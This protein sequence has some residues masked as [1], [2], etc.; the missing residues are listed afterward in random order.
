MKR[1]TVVG[2]EFDSL[3]GHISACGTGTGTNIKPAICNA[4]RQMFK[5]PQLKYAHIGSFRMSVVVK[6]IKNPETGQE[7]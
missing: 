6:L 7:K 1:V 5:S 4:V 2:Y 3:P